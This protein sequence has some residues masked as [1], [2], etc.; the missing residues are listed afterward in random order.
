MRTLS[1]S[2]NP[3]LTWTRRRCW[4]ITLL[5]ASLVLG[6][7]AVAR[8]PQHLIEFTHSEGCWGGAL[9][10]D[11]LHCYVLEEAQREGL[12][13]VDGVFVVGRLLRMYVTEDDLPDEELV[14]FLVAKGHE[15][16]D[17]WPGRVSY[18]LKYSFCHSELEAAYAECMLRDTF[19]AVPNINPWDSPYANIMLWPGGSES[20]FTKGGWASWRQLWPREERRSQARGTGR[21]AGFDV[22]GI[23]V[24]NFPELGCAGPE[25]RD[26]R[27]CDYWKDNPDVGMAGLHG[28]GIE[29]AQ[30]YI[31]IKAPPGEEG[32]LEKSRDAL[33]QKYGFQDGETLTVIPVN[34]DFEEM[35]R[36]AVVLNRFAASPGN[37]IG[38]QNAVV[39]ANVPSYVEGTVWPVE[40]FEPVPRALKPGEDYP[41][42]TRNTVV[43]GAY[44]AP[45]MAQVFPGLLTQLGIPVDAVGIIAQV[46]Q[47]PA[48]G[49]HGEVADSGGES[50]GVRGATGWPKGWRPEVPVWAFYAAAALWPGPDSPGISTP[51]DTAVG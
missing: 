51:G 15:F 10:E 29:G 28:G 35:R 5:A 8:G 14:E 17:R 43:V 42:Y 6:S 37:T 19:W 33:I 44:D 4:I 34:Y 3:L 27:S 39:S 40:G 18:N 47:Y 30:V 48:G 7:M 22:S 21:A 36:W 11:P 32:N 23:D 31:Q 1:N 20:R 50:G 12:I 13:T 9:S 24:T 46:G 16:I 49:R 41:S 26:R 45:R 2:T 38:L 25:L